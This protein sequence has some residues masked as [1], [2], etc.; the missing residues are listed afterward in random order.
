MT[1]G[2]LRSVSM[3]GGAL[4]SYSRIMQKYKQISDLVKFQDMTK[5]DSTWHLLQ[6]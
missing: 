3:A 4:L 1:C 6:A 2:A 5:T